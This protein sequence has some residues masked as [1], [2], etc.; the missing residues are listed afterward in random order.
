MRFKSFLLTTALCLAASSTTATPVIGLTFEG[1]P[2]GALIDDFY[3]DLGVDFSGS[4]AQAL[5]DSDVVGVGT[6]NFE[7]EPSP[8]TVLFFQSGPAILNFADGFMTGFSFF[9]SAGLQADGMTPAAAFVEVY[10]EINAGGTALA[11]FDLTSNW[12]DGCENDDETFCNW[13]PIGVGFAGT[14]RSILFGGD[15]ARVGFD[16]VTFGAVS[17][18]PLPAT[19]WLLA[20]A[21]GGL[22][23]FRRL[24]R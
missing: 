19:V 6:G 9:Y 1:I 22:L 4:G 10:P 15:A 12:Q 5:I 24:R 16:N 2:D 7:N 23:G 20:S 18:I 11:M 8:S 3:I 13:D 21:L 14:A 17:P